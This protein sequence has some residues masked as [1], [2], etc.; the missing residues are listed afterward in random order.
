MSSLTEQE[1]ERAYRIEKGGN[2]QAKPQQ[3]SPDSK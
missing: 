1:Y 3:F 2:S